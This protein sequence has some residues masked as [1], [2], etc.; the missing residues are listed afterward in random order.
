MNRQTFLHGALVLMISGLVTRVMGFVYRVLLTR[1]IGAQ[2]MGLFQIVFPILGLVLTFVTAGL[3]LAI[4]KLVAEA[5]AQNDKARVRRIM[6]ISV[7]IV[8]VLAILFTIL[9]V[10]CRHVVANR[11]LTDPRAYPAYLAMIPLIGVIAISSLYRGYFQGLQDMGPTAWGLILEQ[12]VRIISV[13]ILA[14]YFVHISL[15]Y[16][17]AAAMMGM[18]LGE[19]SGLLFLVFQ[20]RRRGK[21]DDI[22]PNADNRTTETTRDTIRAMRVIAL[23][24]TL[25]KLIWSILFAAEPVLVMRALKHA[26]FSTVMSTTM[27]GQYSGMAIPLLVFP[28]VFTGSLATN[29]VPSVSESI[30]ANEAFRVRIRL[31]QSFTA[32]AMVAFPTAVVLTMFATPL[33]HYIYKEGSVGPI[34]AVMAP[35]MFFLCLQA[36]LT[37]I[38]QGLNKTG[39][40]MTNSIIGGLL[41]LLLIILLA[42]RPTMGVLG[43]S[44]ATAASF[45]VSCILNLW[46]VVRYVGFSIRLHSL[47]RVA[48]ASCGMFVYMQAITMRHTELPL[49]SLMLAVIGGFILYF[50]LLCALRVLTSRNIRRVPRV[51]PW[52][53]QVVKWMPFA[54]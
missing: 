26:G 19:L 6:R 24:V 27:Y 38:L 50:A 33:T 29:L 3:P 49:S 8:A 53:S 16:A 37:G 48:V 45:S 41:K 12:T 1:L 52:L 44:M 15:A 47:A 9:M 21:L 40:A 5:V 23:P 54:I 39:I 30:A 31:A 18:V 14:A 20:Q 35:F 32:T 13:W 4:S 51:G 22:L 28:T 7:W 25:S 2:G 46:F 17:A 42:S 34:L 10:V 36:P 11:W 43:V